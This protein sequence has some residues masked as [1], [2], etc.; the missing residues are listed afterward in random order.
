[1]DWITVEVAR[2]SWYGF[3]IDLDFGALDCDQI[4]KSCEEPFLLTLRE[5]LIEQELPLAEEITTSH[6]AQTNPLKEFSERH[7]Y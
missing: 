7:H 3:L 1:M 5:P 2:S 4:W 6:R